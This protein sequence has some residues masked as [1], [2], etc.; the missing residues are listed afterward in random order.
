MRHIFIQ[1]TTKYSPIHLDC[2]LPAHSKQTYNYHW[3]I[4]Y[5]TNMSCSTWC[6]CTCTHIKWRHAQQREVQSSFMGGGGRGG[7]IFFTSITTTTINCSHIKILTLNYVSEYQYPLLM[8]VLYKISTM[9]THKPQ[10]IY[11]IQSALH[12]SHSNRCT[13][14]VKVC[15]ICVLSFFHKSCMHART[16]QNWLI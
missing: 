5:Y 3:V 14:I 13:Y 8:N 6:S 12:F 15:Y 11:F 16:W 2:F 9:K 1:Q 10:N 4:T 7:V